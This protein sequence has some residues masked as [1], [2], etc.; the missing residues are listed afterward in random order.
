[1]AYFETNV[2]SVDLGL[3]VLDKPMLVGSSAQ[4]ARD[5]ST[6]P[7]GGTIAAVW[8]TVG[9]TAA[10]D[11]SDSDFP[12]SAASDLKFHP[13][14]KPNT[15]APTWYLVMSLRSVAFDVIVIGGDNFGL[16]ATGSI[17][18]N[19]QVADDGV[20]GPLSRVFT[21]ATTGPLPVG[22]VGRR[23]FLALQQVPPIAAEYT[24]VDFLRLEITGLLSPFVP[25]IGEVWLGSRRQMAQGGLIPWDRATFESEVVDTVA[26]S[27]VVTRY[28]LH[29]GRADTTLVLNPAADVDKDRVNGFWEDCNFGAL[30]VLYVPQP[31]S[32][33]DRAY[34]M[35]ATPPRMVAPIVGPFEQRMTIALRE[36]APFLSNE[37]LARDGTLL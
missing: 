27:G 7:F 8:N 29:H 2:D 34:V 32:Q 25:E 26:K 35:H 21:V 20:F 37:L 15:V 33:V 31:G 11:S 22:N 24:N 9:T 17:T 36:T 14:T 13:V 18:M 28:E 4:H 1:M 19:V 30:P 6:G 23:V 10:G 3:K 16:H 5:R 12:T